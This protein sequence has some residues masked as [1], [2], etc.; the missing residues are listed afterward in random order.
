MASPPHIGER[1]ALLRAWRGMTQEE[2]AFAAGTGVDVVRRLE[3][4]VRASA[5][6]TTLT[7]LAGALDVPVADLL[8]GSGDAGPQPASNA[9]DLGDVRRVLT[10][11]DVLPG[12]G[13]MAPA[14]GRA[15]DLADLHT[16]TDRMWG[17]YQNGAY[18]PVARLLPDLITDARRAAREATG[19]DRVAAHSVLATAYQ[20]GAGVAIT[21]GHEDL[22]FIAVE[23]AVLAAELCGDPLHRAAA[24][25][26]L[27]WIYRR[28]G[29]L[30]EAEEV[31]T[32]AAEQCEPRWLQADPGRIAVFGGLLLN[33]SGAAA[34]AGHAQRARDLTRTARA[35]AERLGTD[36]IDRWAVFGP[37]VVAMTEVN[38][39]VEYGDPE[40]GLALVCRVPPRGRVPG[41]WVARYLLNVAEV[42]AG[43]GGTR[44]AG[45]ALAEARR[46]APEW[47]RYHPQARAAVESLLS[48]CRRPPQELVELAAHLRGA[49]PP[50]K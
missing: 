33:A 25:N 36:R 43:K 20:A 8:S 48:R 29:R 19:A 46:L 27:S 11:P 28:H 16:C 12:F 13:G 14:P 1:L 45:E 26:F 40:E 6:L 4:G 47:V 21:L 35:A 44:A 10:S 18:G 3:Q 37:S 22:A 41:T 23:R 34:R 32:R 50:P 39:A 7:A 9:T 49:A 31:A 42:Q 5:R 30:A 38:N 24:A 2:L 15:T 17:R